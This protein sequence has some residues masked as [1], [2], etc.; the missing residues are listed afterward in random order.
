MN[1]LAIALVLPLLA[2]AA[3]PNEK[4]KQCCATLKDADKECVDRF[5][6]FNAIS[7]ANVSAG[8]QRKK[9]EKRIWPSGES[10]LGAQARR[11][12]AQATRP[13]VHMRAILNFMSTCGERG[14]TVGQMWD[15]A[16]LRHNHEQCCIN[17]GVS[18]ECLKYCTAHKGAPSDYLNYAFCTENFNEIRDCFHEHLDKNEPFK[19]L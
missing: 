19:K 5:C 17:K 18:G 3:T 9:K 14:P 1:R 10:N 16:S 11:A 2:M 12:K 4:L 7:Q 8:R 13:L 6:D 15:C